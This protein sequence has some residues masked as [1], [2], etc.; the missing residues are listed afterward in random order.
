MATDAGLPL[1]LGPAD[2]I[3]F[4]IDGFGS[5]L[6]MT[7]TVLDHLSRH[8]QTTCWKREAGGQLFASFDGERWIVEK[9]TG[10]RRS[11]L[12]S[13]FG[14]RPDRRAEQHEIDQALAR[15]FHF[16]GDWHTHPE[17]V[18]RPS[19]DDLESVAE[20]V[21]L[22]SHELPGFVMVIVGQQAP[23]T[24]LWVSFHYPDGRYSQLLAVSL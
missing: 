11:D 8:R 9:V 3:V 1:L 20:M 16:I 6:E 10:P 22:S 23:P 2:M 14:F 13:R 21:S 7:D 4:R 18:P 24:G 19:I 5:S 17:P 15:G 12:R